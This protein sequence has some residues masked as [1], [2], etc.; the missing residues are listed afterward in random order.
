MTRFVP[1]R[2]V[3]GSTLEIDVNRKR[4]A[5]ALGVEDSIQAKAAFTFP[6]VTISANVGMNLDANMANPMPCG[7]ELTG[8]SVDMSSLEAR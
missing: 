4:I 8:A 2:L 6:A 5:K 7:I 1:S 3:G